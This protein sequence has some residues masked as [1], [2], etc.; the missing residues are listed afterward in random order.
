M[1]TRTIAGQALLHEVEAFLSK[2]IHGAVIGGREVFA[3]NGDTFDTHDPGSGKKLATVANMQPDDVESAVAAAQEA[4]DKAD[5]ARLP[6]N[7]RG[8]LLMRL[9]DTV[10]QHKLIITQIESP[11]CGKIAAQAEDDVQN[12]ID[13]VRYF[14]NLAQGLSLDTVIPV[15]GHEASV[16]RHAW[17]PCGFIVPWNFPFLLCGWGI[18][19]AMAAGNTCVVKPAEDTPLSTLYVGT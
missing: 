6:A 9:A 16:V 11:D 2:E 8:V 19:P 3:S 5:W 17:G 10:E 14:C 12:F 7:E 1:S 15:A 13:T 4:F 18:G